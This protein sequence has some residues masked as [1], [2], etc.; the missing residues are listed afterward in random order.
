[1]VLTRAQLILLI[2]RIKFEFESMTPDYAQ[3]H[4]ELGYL[5]HKSKRLQEAEASFLRA[6]ELKPDFAEAHN[7]L[8]NLLYETNR[9]HEAEA[10]FRRALELNPDLAQSHNNL[11]NLL[12]VTKRLGE[13]EG[14]FRK[15][16]ELNPYF[17][18]AHNNLGNLLK[19]RN[20][21]Q[22]AET[23]FM[24]ALE[25]KPDLTVAHI[26]LGS[27]YHAMNR[28]PEAKASFLLALAGQAVY[29][30]SYDN[31]ESLLQ[32][33]K[34]QQE[35][36]TAYLRTSELSPD[37]S[38]AYYQLGILFQKTKHLPN[39]EAVFRRVL[40]LKP[41]HV[42]AF[43]S[44]GN[45][46]LETKRF[47]EA[48]TAFRHALQLEPNFA[49]A[50]NNLGNVLQVT[51]RLSEAEASY[52]RSLE[53]KPDYADANVNLGIL[54]YPSKRLLEAE[55]AFRRALEVK[56]NF[57]EAQWNLSLLLL[58]QGRYA[59]AWPYYESRY[60]PNFSEAYTKIPCFSFSQWKGENLTGKSLVLCPEQGFGDT[61]QFSRY[62]PILKSLGVS[63]LTL[64]CDPSLKTLFE[65]IE[66][67]DAVITDFA[68]ITVH[69]YWSFLLSVPLHVGTTL[70]NLPARLP[71]LH[72]L[73]ERVSYWR[74]RLPQK[75]L[76]VGLVW[77]G[78]P[79]N[80]N[81]AHRSIPQFSSLTPLWSLPEVTFIGLQAGPNVNR[82][83]HS[84]D[85]QPIIQFG[86]EL[87]DFADTAAIVAQLDLVICVDTAI[88]HLAGALGKPCW[89]LLPAFGS[90]WR[91]LLDRHDSPWYPEVVRIFRQAELN[92]W[93]QPIGEIV[94]ALK[95]WAHST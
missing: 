69:D 54:L 4:N 20:L 77:Q 73:P 22:E 64:V 66:G 24:R 30:E 37:Y 39:S 29:G 80:K 19:E 11:G 92:Q 6:L 38:E 71:Y 43:N 47:K 16:L 67:V 40:V 13:A 26:N 78:N 59:E 17:A 21:F 95:D 27:L 7:N 31:V 62:V 60:D 58:T 10:V 34:Q 74:D 49:E 9:L 65:T 85:I 3:A 23:V 1:M 72:A 81:D 25:L 18:E 46:L 57:V 53:L 12:H 75:G 91:W 51:G 50:F 33:I 90:D 61:I 15:A 63:F 45:V 56:P 36:E 42:G 52:R 35:N 70:D 84:S 89:L 82:V 55:V 14:A 88:V 28:L 32:K 8:G 79:E 2:L 93:E 76:R 41:N 48:E 86:S 83:M 44:L 5:L 87:R 94:D 68:G